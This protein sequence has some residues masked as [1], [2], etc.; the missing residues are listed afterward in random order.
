MVVVIN[1]QKSPTLAVIKSCG[2]FESANS[3]NVYFFTFK[4]LRK[5]YC[6]AQFN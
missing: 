3:L 2:I 4:E 5:K 6:I 1:T